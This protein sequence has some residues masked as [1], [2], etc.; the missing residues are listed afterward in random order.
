MP[1]TESR[2]PT[3]PSC[4]AP[5]AIRLIDL[6]ADHLREAEAC[7]GK[8]LP[9]CDPAQNVQQAAAMLQQAVGSAAGRDGLGR[10]V[11][12][13]RASHV[14]PRTQPAPTHGIS[15]TR[16]PPRCRWPACSMPS[17]RSPIRPWR[18]T[19]WAPGQRLPEWAMVQRLGQQIGWRDGEFSGLATHGG[20]LANLTALLT[21][22]NVSLGDCWEQGAGRSGPPPVIGNPCRR[23][24]QRIPSG[25]HPGPRNR[26]R[27]PRKARPA[28]PHG[29]AA[30]GRHARRVAGQEP[31]DRCRG[32]PAPVPL[33]SV[34]STC[35]TRWPTCAA[36]MPSGCTSTRPMA[37]Q[38]ALSPRYRRLVAGLER[39]DSLVW[40][41]H[42]MLFV[43]A[44][45]AFVLYRNQ[46]HRFETFRQDAPYLFDPAAPGVADFDSAL[47][48]IECTKRAAAFGLWGVWSM[49]GP[50]ALCRPGRHHL[51][52]GP[53]VL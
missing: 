40:D 22:R 17:D 49:F 47:R 20:S 6:L 45:C 16:L 43:P 28:P 38:P 21:A 14:G 24:L 12:S 26:P 8:V 53:G 44:L 23:S 18:F 3:I 33:R 41:A 36:V 15:A 30:T 34:R 13:D 2:W 39:A 25:G 5:P 46:A 31:A 10:S 29:P 11:L 1:G 51:F 52:D 35:S 7:G 9:W 32:G 19:T 37:G 48:T 4:C 27:D 42:K 50:A